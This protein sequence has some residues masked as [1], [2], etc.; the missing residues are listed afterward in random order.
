[1]TKHE[2]IH[3]ILNERNIDLYNFW[4]IKLLTEYSEYKQKILDYWGF[5]AIIDNIVIDK[6]KRLYNGYNDYKHG[7][8]YTP[9]DD[10]ETE[11]Y[12]NWVLRND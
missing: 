11:G 7:F 6:D 3:Q 8:Y 1:M 4:A 12:L 2:L 9:G 10:F 5:N